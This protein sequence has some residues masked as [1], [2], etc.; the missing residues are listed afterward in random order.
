MYTLT[1]YTEENELTPVDG[2][3]T[4]TSTALTDEVS[5]VTQQGSSLSY[6]GELVIAF[7]NIHLWNHRET[8]EYLYIVYGDD[9]GRSNTS[10]MLL[11]YKCNQNCLADPEVVAVINGLPVDIDWTDTMDA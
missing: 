1:F 9:V 6:D 5:W 4:F 10:F 2:V 8:T 11:D 3:Y 7:S